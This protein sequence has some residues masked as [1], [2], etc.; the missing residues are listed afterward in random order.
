MGLF[1]YIV[2]GFGWEVGSQ[3]ARES[4][5][6]LQRRD[7]DPPPPMTARE[8]RQ[9]ERAREKQEAAERE[10]RVAAAERKRA[11]IEAELEALKKKAR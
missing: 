3:A 5:D 4:I 8:L 11:S 1:K 9:L 7:D 2:Q 10:E 6:A